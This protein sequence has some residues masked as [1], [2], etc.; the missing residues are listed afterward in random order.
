M[1]ASRRR[2]LVAA[3]VGA[4]AVGLGLF[5][6][7]QLTG[8]EPNQTAGPRIVQPGAPGQSGRVLSPDEASTLSPPAH[9]A[10]D[11]L[12]MQRMIPHHAQALEMTALVAG[13]GASRE[14]SLLAKRIDISQ[15]DEIAQMQRWLADRG[16]E[17]T[18]PHAHHSGHHELMPGMLDDEQLKQLEQARGAE[19]DRRFLQF[20]IYH[21]HGALAMVRELYETGGGLEPASDRFAREVTAD[22]SIEIRSMQGLL[23]KLT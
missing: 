5:V 22:Q 17:V 4:V 12:F 15:R 1:F 18:E 21:H 20:M 3:M 9:T 10:A 16:E 23:A 11:T 8:D 13:R 2:L 19:F 14:V 6:V 7:F